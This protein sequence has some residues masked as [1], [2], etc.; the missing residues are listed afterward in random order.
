VTWKIADE[1]ASRDLTILELAATI[2]RMGWVQ[3][4]E[5]QE[6]SLLIEC[7]LAAASSQTTLVTH[8]S[9]YQLV[10]F[11]SLMDSQMW[12]ENI[13]SLAFITYILTDTKQSP[14]PNFRVCTQQ[15]QHK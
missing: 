13:S 9:S 8:P 1:N 4:G 15:C 14:I 2:R 3:A 7:A 11:L 5:A 12:L 6:E 10:L